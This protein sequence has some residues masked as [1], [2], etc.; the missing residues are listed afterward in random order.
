[1]LVLTRPRLVSSSVSLAGEEGGGRRRL[2]PRLLSLMLS[3]LSLKPTVYSDRRHRA[4]LRN[5]WLAGTEH[6]C[7]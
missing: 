3:I 2:V 1:M 5:T 6:A 4:L 7:Q